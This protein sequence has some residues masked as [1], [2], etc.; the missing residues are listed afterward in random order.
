[1]NKSAE[2]L[3]KLLNHHS[4]PTVWLAKQFAGEANIPLSTAKSIVA[5][6]LKKGVKHLR[7]IN[8]YRKI[9]SLPSDYNFNAKH[10]GHRWN[11]RY[12]SVKCNDQLAWNL[13]QLML[14]KD[15]TF[16]EL[17]DSIRENFGINYRTEQLQRHLNGNNCSIKCCYYYAVALEV[18]MDNLVSEDTAKPVVFERKKVL[19]I[20]NISKVFRKNFLRLCRLHR[21]DENRVWLLT[22]V[23]LQGNKKSWISLNNATTLVKF[24]GVKLEEFLINE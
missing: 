17:R 11:E 23:R 13:S 3:N 20:D 16:H 4:K 24:F 21:T 19:G 10:K 9:F 6:H 7:H 5:N 1:M 12:P 22:G 15:F 14:D 8:T 18:S 2:T